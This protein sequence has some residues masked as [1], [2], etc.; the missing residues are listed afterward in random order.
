MAAEEG[1]AEVDETG[2]VGAGLVGDGAD[3]GGFVAL[4]FGDG[5]GDAVLADDGDVAFTFEGADGVDGTEG[6][7]VGGGGDEDVLVAGV[8]IEEV[9][10]EL[11]GLVAEAA[12]VHADEDFYGEVGAGI[13]NAFEGAGDAALDEGAGF[14]EIEAESPVDFAG[15][16]GE[17]V[18]GEGFAGF[19]ADAVVVDAEVGGVGVGDVDGDEGDVGGGD[20]VADDG[21]YVLLDLELDDEV[22][23][24]VDELF[25]V[26]EGGGAVVGVVE[27]EEVDADGGCRGFEAFGDFDR[28]GHLGTLAGEAKADFLWRGDVAVGAIGGVREV[29]AMDEGLE[30]S[31]DG[32]LGDAGFAVNGLEGEGLTFRLEELEDIDR[33]GEDG[34]EVEAF[35]GFAGCHRLE[36]LGGCNKIIRSAG[37]RRIGRRRWHCGRRGRG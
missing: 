12:A 10:D 9:G 30:D 8:A 6:G 25:C 34:D 20:A 15:P 35:C 36:S 1:E 11:A 23:F 24:A 22:D 3:E 31:V 2:A 5:F 14:G 32:G 21:G 37:A 27:D 19:D 28:E 13:A 4:H 17:G 7:G 29:A 18:G 26:A 33:L 16:V